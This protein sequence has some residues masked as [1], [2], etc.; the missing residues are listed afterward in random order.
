MA[1]DTFGIKLKAEGE[2]EFRSILSHIE[3]LLKN[4]G[5]GLA[6]AA[7]QAATGDKNISALAKAYGELDGKMSETERGLSEL[8]TRYEQVA[9]SGLVSENELLK[10][11]TRM[12]NAGV[13]AVKLGT[14]VDTV[15][16]NL[17]GMNKNL[18]QTGTSTKTFATYMASGATSTERLKGAAANLKTSTKELGTSLADAAREAGIFVKALPAKA[19]DGIKAG[20]ESTK[21]AVTTFANPLNIVGFAMEKLS[22]LTSRIAAGFQHFGAR[23]AGIGKG[24]EQI[25]KDADVGAVGLDKLAD[26]TGEVDR[27]MG[28]AGKSTSFFRDALKAD[29]VSS[30]IKA[31]LRSLVNLLKDVGR[32]LMDSARDGIAYTAE[33]QQYTAAYTVLLGDEA[34]AQQK[35]NELRR[36]AM[37][38]PYT[39]EDLGRATKT[40][41]SY[42]V[43]LDDVSGKLS[44]LED[45]AMG[46]AERLRS[47]TLAFSQATAAGKLQ[48]QDLRQMID[49][50]FNPLQ[51]MVAMT[52]KSLSYFQS[53]MRKGAITT[54]MMYEAFQHA[55][56]EGGRFYQAMLKFSQTYQGQVTILQ[57]SI[58]NL[59]GL[60]TT[61]LTTLLADSVLPMFNRW[62]EQLT[63]GFEKQ[64]TQGLLNAL[65][66][67]VDEAIA[68]VGERLGSVADKLTGV[69]SRVFDTLGSMASALMPFLSDSML[70]LTRFLL[71]RAP[72]MVRAVSSMLTSIVR[73]FGR[74]LP[75]LVKMAIQAIQELVKEAPKLIGEVMTALGKSL[76][77]FGVSANVLTPII[78]GLT[79]AFVAYKVAVAAANAAM[80]IG[81]TIKSLATM[82]GTLTTAT[83]AATAAQVALNTAQKANAIGLVI[84]AV[85]GL[86]TAFGTLLDPTKNLTEEEK[87]A[88]AEAENL[89]DKLKTLA[90]ESDTAE[91]AVKDLQDAAA[92]KES[93]FTTLADRI[94][95]LAGKEEKTTAE[96]QEL[97]R[98]INEINRIYPGVN[99]KLDEHGDLLETNTGRYYDNVEGIKALAKALTA[100]M[101]IEAL[102]QQRIALEKERDALA[103]LVNPAKEFVASMAE[104]YNL[105][106]PEAILV[107]AEQAEQ[108]RNANAVLD[109][110]NSKLDETQAK[111]D[112][113]NAEIAANEQLLNESTAATQTHTAALT[114]DNIEKAKAAALDAEI[115]AR[116]KELLATFG[117]FEEVPKPGEILQEDKAKL[118]AALASQAEALAGWGANMTS[119]FG[120]VGDEGAGLMEE[121]RNLG[122]DAAA[123]VAILNSM[124]DAELAKYVETWKLREEAA[125]AIAVS[126]VTGIKDDTESTLRDMEVDASKAGETVMAT[127]AT[128]AE[129]KKPE[130]QTKMEGIIGGAAEAAVTDNQ[131]L[132]NAGEQAD[133][134]FAGGIENNAS[135]PI[136]SAE[137]VAQDTAEAYV[138]DETL[139]KDAGEKSDDIIAQGMDDNQQALTDVVPP[140][141]DGVVDAFDDQQS[142]LEGAGAGVTEDAA[143]GAAGETSLFNDVGNDMGAAEEAGLK[144][145][146][147]DISSAARAGVDSA[148]TSAN[149]GVSQFWS[150]GADSASGMGGGWRSLFPSIRNRIVSDVKGLARD[151]Q[152]AMAIGSPSK[153]FMDIGKNMGLGM[154]VGFTNIMKKVSQDMQ[155]AI[156]TAF[157]A[158]AVPYR[159]PG[160]AALP[161]AS[162]YGEGMTQTININSP[163]ALSERE[164]A[165]QFRNLS[166]KLAL[167]V[168]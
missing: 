127:I 76:E 45:I 120:R 134:V 93:R 58:K 146:S 99:F 110:H 4:V 123:Q 148:Y 6:L 73:E 70:T 162:G 28:K 79:A 155:N 66:K 124:T 59:K 19:M 105:G 94:F 102:E 13:A 56:S 97:N 77:G 22:G 83:T 149:G 52:G 11:Q 122:P 87:K 31:G 74:A 34:K 151:V 24:V 113:V 68:Y 90:T 53:E 82:F 61:E 15:G 71:S 107:P 14:D 125:R 80:A 118:T 163:K 132:I 84:A 44:Q 38:T 133:D 7:A 17:G 1:Q 37:R 156:P 116:Q 164:V 95:E 18:S 64:G 154:G 75:E 41:L 108:L 135:A 47:L 35:V 142:K 10:L 144:D 9:A 106:T 33:M 86:V 78:T 129:S 138:H 20:I 161:I 36:E 91:Q 139:W 137:Q 48:G 103:E 49:A 158:S 130:F 128:G 12:N 119:L 5:S 131:Q 57:G 100:S 112:G 72:E 166:R 152:K 81:G 96:T 104:L 51:E 54:E 42:G 21:Q 115:E 50:G 165:R 30:A 16:T 114:A 147:K 160:A 167:E 126:E 85:A 157:T 40:L 117:L 3:T 121:L 111:L 65:G 2:R 39:M 140:L 69:A 109:E 168:G 88:A 101:N 150:I 98:A 55:T 143:H 32:A 92:D 159:A 43:S 29:L 23:I 46:D 27:E 153:V 26:S 25:G 60:I 89:A 136:D 8:S 62:T 141:V 63:A 145:K 67:V